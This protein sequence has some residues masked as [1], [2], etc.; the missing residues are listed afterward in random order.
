MEHFE[1]FDQEILGAPGGNSSSGGTSSTAQ[2]YQGPGRSPE[3]DSAKK[4]RRI[5]Y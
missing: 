4:R 3:A 5:G 2:G 1:H